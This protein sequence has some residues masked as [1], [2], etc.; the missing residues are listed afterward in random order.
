MYVIFAHYCGS[1]TIALL[2]G[3]G[4][5]PINY[6]L[7]SLRWPL[8]AAAAWRPPRAP[9]PGCRTSHPCISAGVG[10]AAAAEGAAAVTARGCTVL[11]MPCLAAGDLFPANCLSWYLAG[12]SILASPAFPP[13]LPNPGRCSEMKPV[14]IG[15][16]GDTGAGKSSMLNALLGEEEVLPQN[17]MRACTACVVEVSYAPSS[18][19]AAEI[20]FVSEVSFLSAC[21][22]ARIARQLQY[23]MRLVRLIVSMLCTSSCVLLCSAL[24]CCC[25]CR[26]CCAAAGR[27]AGPGGGPVGGSDRR[28]GA[29][30]DCP[31]RPQPRHALHARCCTGMLCTLCIC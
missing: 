5:V 4:H 17:G 29:A 26:A 12:F 19:Y 11:N 18:A 2:A 13:T 22:Q 10:G 7:S 14:V 31:R 24:C 9:R 20:D 23:T 1:C 27:V 28:G 21:Q 25:C 6:A 16:V 15:V 8:Q 3:Q 30:A